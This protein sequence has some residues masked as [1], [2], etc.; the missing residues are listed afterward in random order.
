MEGDL[1]D[2]LFLNSHFS[3]IFVLSIFMFNNIN[4]ETYQ[5][6]Q[7]TVITIKRIKTLGIL[8]SNDIR[9]KAAKPPCVIFLVFNRLGDSWTI[10]DAMCK[11]RAL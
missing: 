2:V 8:S 6:S 11:K 9:T 4:L 7:F 1:I 3:Q 10:Q 5:K